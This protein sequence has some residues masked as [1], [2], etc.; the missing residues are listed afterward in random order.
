MQ[1]ANLPRDPQPRRIGR[2]DFLRHGTTIALGA[3]ARAALRAGIAQAAV[4]TTPQRDLIIL[5]YN[6]VT[7]LDPHRG[8]YA[9][10]CSVAFNVFDTLV[11]RHPD[12]TLRPGLATA[13]ARSGPTTWRL[14]L[15][16]GVRWHDGSRLTA[17]D[18]KYSLDRTFDASLK[19]ACLV[20]LL[21]TIERTEIPD[22]ET[23]V[24]HTRYPDVLIPARLAARSWVV[25]W[26]Y[27]DRVG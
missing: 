13:W 20:P 19:A 8:T 12:G 25:P 18:V 10:D 21:Q 27:V 17:V 23:L 14:T 6:D 4:D 24:I 3:G 22:P 9:S 26:A 1:L 5:Q 15:R 2:R 11:R 16:P 7:A